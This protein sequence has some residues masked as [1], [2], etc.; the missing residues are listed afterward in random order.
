MTV[1]EVLLAKMERV[2]RRLLDEGG[3]CANKVVDLVGDGRRQGAKLEKAVRE[4]GDVVAV[5]RTESQNSMRALAVQ[6]GRMTPKG[7]AE[8]SILGVFEFF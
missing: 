8:G 1:T 2:E 4:L 7:A 3:S 5:A 6:L